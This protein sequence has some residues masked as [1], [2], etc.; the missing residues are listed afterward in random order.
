MFSSQQSDTPAGQTPAPAPPNK[1]IDQSNV[2]MPIPVS[3]PPPVR[4]YT[5]YGTGPNTFMGA[6]DLFK[7]LGSK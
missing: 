3:A 4:T 7:N 5:A 6:P 1:P 2:N